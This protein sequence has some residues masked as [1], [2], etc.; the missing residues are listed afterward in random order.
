MPQK[1]NPVLHSQSEIFS[2]S[3]RDS[4]SNDFYS[5]S[6]LRGPLGTLVFFLGSDCP[7]VAHCIEEILRIANDY[8]VQGIGFIG[9]DANPSGSNSAKN[10]NAAKEFAFQNHFDFPYLF[11]Q[12]QELSKAF[13]LKYFP[14]FYLFD[15]Q[16]TL[17][18][19]GRLDESLPGNGIPLSGSDL[20]HAIDSLVCNR[21]L[22]AAK[23]PGSGC[24]INYA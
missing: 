19:H 11:D 1:S 24:P 8:R 6:D 12:E 7:F 20:R 2:V 18:Y 21:S 10:F 16:N 5:L 23:K 13:D 14:D 15:N 3:L 9:I 22:A 4:N 17:C